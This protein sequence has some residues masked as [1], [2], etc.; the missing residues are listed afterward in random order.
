[1]ETVALNHLLPVLLVLDKVHM[2]SI[3]LLELVFVSLLM[4]GISIGG[5]VLVKHKNWLIKQYFSKYLDAVL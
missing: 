3:S 1:M 5:T 2:V 4:V